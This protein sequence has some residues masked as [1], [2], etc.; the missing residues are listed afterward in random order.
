MFAILHRTA[1][2]SGFVLDKTAFRYWLTWLS[3]TSDKGSRSLAT[4][5]INSGG[6]SDSLENIG[7]CW[8][9]LEK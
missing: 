2:G 8:V 5:D 3:A 1:K 7:H 4:V 6:Q 9:V